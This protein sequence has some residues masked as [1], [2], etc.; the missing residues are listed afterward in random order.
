L[1]RLITPARE[2]VHEMAKF[3]AVGAANV[4]VDV[5][6]FNLLRNH[7]L[8]NKPITDKVI[9]T[10]IAIVS[11]YFM[12]RH[13]TWQDRA[14]TGI[15]RELPLF[16]VL[17]GIGLGI[18]LV[19]L[20]TSHY[21]FGL[22]STWADNISANVIGLGLGMVWRFWAFRRWVFPKHEPAE[23]EAAAEAVIRTTV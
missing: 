9:S 2:L 20:T 1:R 13:W 12:N 5:G 11:S 19:C 21:V 18:S 17:S 4:V 10:S 23:E 22:T 3:G 7:L 14:R 8:P 6:I 16:L 15:H